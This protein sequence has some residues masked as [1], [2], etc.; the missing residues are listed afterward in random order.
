VITR[1]LVGLFLVAHGLVHL[2]YLTPRPEEDQSYPFVPETRWITRALG[3]EPARARK[4]AGALAVVAAVAFAVAGC[5]LIVDAAIW[6]PAAVVASSISLALLLVFFHPWLLIGIGLDIVIIASVVR[7]HV[8][9]A[10]F[11]R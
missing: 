8:P 10:L 2:L 1:I 9:A 7:W 5:A 11:E 3:L 6:Q 4:L